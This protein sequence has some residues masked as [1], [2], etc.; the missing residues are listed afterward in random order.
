M[1]AHY[2]ERRCQ[3]FATAQRSCNTTESPGRHMAWEQAWAG[4]RESLAGAENDG[5]AAT[6]GVVNCQDPTN[7]SPA[8][9]PASQR[10]QIQAENVFWRRS[11]EDGWGGR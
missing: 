11:N 9:T 10:A 1:I 3:I 8:T 6:A 2:D 7:Q 4:L 5:D